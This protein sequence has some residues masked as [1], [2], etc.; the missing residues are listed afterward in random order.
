M[1]TALASTLLLSLFLVGCGGGSSPTPPT[2]PTQYSL[3]LTIAQP[4]QNA[5]DNT[6]PY[7]GSDAIATVTITGGSV[8]DVDYPTQIQVVTTDPNI[9][10]IDT[11]GCLSQAAR[12]LSCQFS[13]HNIYAG[14]DAATPL[15]D[16]IQVQAKSNNNTIQSNAVPVTLQGYP[17]NCSEVFCLE[18]TTPASD[19][20]NDPSFNKDGLHHT[21][22]E[23]Q[24]NLTMGNPAKAFATA[25]STINASAVQVASDNH[26]IGLLDTSCTTDL[27]SCKLTIQNQY[28]GSQPETES[29]TA[30]ASFTGQTTASGSDALSLTLPGL[31][32]CKVVANQAGPDDGVSLKNGNLVAYAGGVSQTQYTS[33]NIK[34]LYPVA[35]DKDPINGHYFALNVSGTPALFGPSA[36]FSVPGAPGITPSTQLDDIDCSGYKNGRV[37]PFTPGPGWATQQCYNNQQIRYVYYALPEGVPPSKNGWPV[38][39]MLQG[40]DGQGIDLSYTETPNGTLISGSATA[41]VFNNTWDWSGWEIN[42][43]SPSGALT[44][45]Y[46][47]SYYVRMRLIQTWLSRGFAVIVPTTWNASSLSSGSLDFWNF[48]PT[49]SQP[50]PYVRVDGSSPTPTNA[51]PYPIA[52]GAMNSALTYLQAGYWPGMDEQFFEALMSYIN[53]PGLVDPWQTNVHFDTR[54]LF[55]MGYSAGGN[56]VSRL[57]NEFKGMSFIDKTT[58]TPAAFPAI[59]G[60][61]ILSGGSYSCYEGGTTTAGTNTCPV[62][63]L[64][65]VGAVEE[66]YQSAGAIKSHPP[67]LVAQSLYDESAGVYVP[68]GD[69]TGLAGSV[70]YQGYL[71]LCPFNSAN[72][73]SPSSCQPQNGGKDGGTGSMYQPDNLIQM[74]HTAN[75][76]VFHYYFPEMVIPSLDLMLKNTCVAKVTN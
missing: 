58:D 37:V 63:P 44:T 21:E 50:W 34:L 20:S 24:L 16:S 55:L 64:T 8:T 60:A 22:L 26:D 25:S 9:M 52:A 61:I 45:N 31:Q 46:S 7:G 43:V 67:T 48:E 62:D 66:N 15:V 47:Y 75:P 40:T 3:Q 2:P 28:I 32:S 65:E 69:E 39:I 56:M 68:G 41:N 18:D 13:I 38:V 59:K 42:P 54:N 4:S 73:A 11:N 30:S 12:Q 29:I 71:G 51:W 5:N 6:L 57:I 14:P 36:K 70:Y 17:S 72:S 19:D 76:N 1:R 27:S 23:Y 53:T 10:I 49:N 35:L 33:A 74:I